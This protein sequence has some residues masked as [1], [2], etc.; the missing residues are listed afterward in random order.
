MGWLQ[1]GMEFIVR[2]LQDTAE[3]MAS[4][5]ERG[6]LIAI[7][8]MITKNRRTLSVFTSLLSFSSSTSLASE[9]Q[10]PCRNPPNLPSVSRSYVYL[11]PCAPSSTLSFPTLQPVSKL[12]FNPAA[13]SESLKIDLS[14]VLRKIASSPRGMTRPKID[15]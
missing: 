14:M 1:S 12:T 4:L 2:G 8:R 6:R 13:S 9:L 11:L 5:L 15:Q 3:V 10:A 7:L